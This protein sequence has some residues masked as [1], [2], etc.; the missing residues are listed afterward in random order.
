MKKKLT[1]L[2]GTMMVVIGLCACGS[3]VRELSENF[4]EAT[5]KAAAEE[6]IGYVNEGDVEGFCSVDMSDAMAENMTVE[7]TQQIFD[8]YLGNKGAFVEYNSITIV[9]ADDKTIGDCAVVVVSA[10][11]ENMNVQYTISYDAGMNL[12]GF[13]LK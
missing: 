13:F 11:Y 4:D 10:K 12:V 2:I 3:G 7:S 1:L 5:V 9:G 6:L 8:Q